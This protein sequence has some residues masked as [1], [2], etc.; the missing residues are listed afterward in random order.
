MSPHLA[1]KRQREL[2]HAGHLSEVK[3]GRPTRAT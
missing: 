1:S 3:P 2:W